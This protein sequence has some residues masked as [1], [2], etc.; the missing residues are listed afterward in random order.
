MQQTFSNANAQTSHSPGRGGTPTLNN[1]G[2][3]LHP[4]LPASAII[5][6]GPNYQHGSPTRVYLNQ[7]VVPVLLEGM[8]FVAKNEFVLPFVFGF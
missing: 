4:N 7:K 8:K 5:P 6:T 2:T 3:G 1:V